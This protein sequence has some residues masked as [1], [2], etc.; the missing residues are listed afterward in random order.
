MEVVKSVN[1]ASRLPPDQKSWIQ[2]E[3]LD[4]TIF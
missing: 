2:G 4:S 1:V 3:H